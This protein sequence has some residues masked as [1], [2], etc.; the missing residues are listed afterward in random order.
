MK[1]L[2]DFTGNELSFSILEHSDFLENNEDKKLA[3]T[4]LDNNF[5]KT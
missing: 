1:C 3:D 4:L 2:E 5:L